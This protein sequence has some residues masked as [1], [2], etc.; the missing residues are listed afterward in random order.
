MADLDTG[1]T[2]RFESIGRETTSVHEWE[3]DSQYLVPT[4]GFSFT[5]VEQDRSLLRGLDLL[6]I[7]LLVN[8]KSQLLGQ[9]EPKGVGGHEVLGIDL[10]LVNVRRLAADA[11]EADR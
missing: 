4:D 5:L 8:G 10:P 11:L 9:R 7:E 3:I 1:L 6:P 2:V